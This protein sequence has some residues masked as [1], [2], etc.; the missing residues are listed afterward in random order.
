MKR[1]ILLATILMLF[2]L[3]GCSVEPQVMIKDNTIT[4]EVADTPDKKMRG[5]MY[6]GS[7]PE[8]RGMLFVF[9]DQRMQ[10]FWMKNT[11]ISLDLIFISEDMTITTIFEADPCEEDPCQTY[12]AIAKYV[13]EVNK[14]YSKTH[15]INVGDKVVLKGVK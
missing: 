1:L 5:L 12:D 9:E 14:G 3:V 4:I 8:D 6:R 13:L 7:L 2:L 15:D 11:L 10:G